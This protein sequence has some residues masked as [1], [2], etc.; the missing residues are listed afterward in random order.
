VNWISQTLAVTALNIRTIPQRLG[1]SAVAVVGIAG[2]VIVFVAVLSIAEGFRKVMTDAGSPDTAIVLRAGSDTEMTS[3]LGGEQARLITEAPAI[4]RG[5]NGPIASQE[6]FV[7]VAVPKRSTGTDANVPLRGVNPQAFEVR[8]ELSIVEGRRFTPGRN[9]VI[10]G[11]A[12]A[13]EFDLQLGRSEKWGEN[14]WDVVGI[15]E[16]DGSI[17]ES[18][19]WTDARVLQPAYR[20]GNSYQSVYAKLDSAEAFDKFK[21]ALTTDP[22]LNVSVVRENDY[23]A[24][25]SVVLQ[26]V[27]R[28]IGYGIAILMG[29]G[30]VFGAINTMYTAVATRTR[31]IATLRALGFGAF[32]VLI[33]VIAEAILLSLV[34]GVVGGALAYIAFDGFQAATMNW[35]SFS[36][37]A[38]AFAVTPALLAQGIGSAV[39]MGLLGGLLPAIRAARLPIVAALR[40][41]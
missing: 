11:R 22:R 8:P 16:S 35:Q 34:G 6:L 24:G 13:R 9:E 29:I 2:V 21:D 36:Q 12:A 32:A 27:V 20:R 1:S 4:E 31:E 28:T 26:T 3:G 5:A 14:T 41:L 19:V 18:E 30:A 23:F 17:S 7:I 37:V 25:Q 15:F 10:V 38:F 40:E 33:S 39:V